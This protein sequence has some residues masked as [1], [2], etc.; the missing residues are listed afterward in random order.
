MR[1]DG[2]ETKVAVTGVVKELQADPLV[3]LLFRAAK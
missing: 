1:V 3:E 2:K